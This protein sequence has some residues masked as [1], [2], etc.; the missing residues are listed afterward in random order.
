DDCVTYG[1]AYLTRDE[2]DARVEQLLNEYYRYLSTNALKRRDK[3]FWNYH[4]RR[5]QEIG[6]PFDRLRLSKQVAMKLIDLAINPKQTAQL[7]LG[8]RR[9]RQL[10]AGEARRTATPGGS[11]AAANW[12]TLR[13]LPRQRDSHTNRS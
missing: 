9:I 7:M 8:R 11:Q 5:L 10:A 2:L 13:R 1:M 6:F 4:K 12:R 3:T